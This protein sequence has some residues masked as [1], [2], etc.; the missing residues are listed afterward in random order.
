MKGSFDPAGWSGPEMDIPRDEMLR[1]LK[2]QGFDALTHT[3]GLRTAVG[4]EVGPHQVVIGLD[5]N[6]VLGT[7][8]ATPYRQWEPWASALP[9]G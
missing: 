5:P 4:Q 1:F 6:D 8:R 9:G 7:G 2:Q 3:G